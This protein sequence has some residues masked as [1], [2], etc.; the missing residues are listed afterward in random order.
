MN[1]GLIIATLIVAGIFFMYRFIKWIAARKKAI[2]SAAGAEKYGLTEELPRDEVWWALLDTRVQLELAVALARKALPVWQKYSEAN[3]LVYQ[4]SSMG[5][6]IK[7]KPCLLQRSLDE[8]AQNSNLRFPEN[9]KG[10]INC[11]NEFVAP[12]IAL[13]DGNWAVIYPVKKI[14]LA[15]YNIL[16]A[17]A[18]QE[19]ITV[20]KNL[21]ALSVNQSLDCLDMCK[22]YSSEEIKTFLHP[23]RV[24][25]TS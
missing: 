24:Q 17:I 19:N 2:Q 6:F 18:E 11:Y 13:Q 20:M 22:L 4:N 3:E 23:Y 25:S 14:F 12:L 16:K 7:I 10:I 1:T 15:V 5:P 9:N 8:I 21:F